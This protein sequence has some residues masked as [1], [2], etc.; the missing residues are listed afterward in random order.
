ML[1]LLSG[2]GPT[3]FGRTKLGADGPEF[4]P[5]PMAYFI[6]GLFQEKYDYSILENDT[7]QFRFI[8]EAELSEF[9]K[10]E[11]AKNQRHL[12]IPGLKNHQLKPHGFMAR[13]L[14]W[15]AAALK[16]TEGIDTVVPVFFR[17]TDSPEQE[18]FEEKLAS[19]DNGFAAAGFQNRGVAMLAKP[20]SEAWLLCLADDYQNGDKYEKGPGNDDSPNSLKARL[21]E[22][23]NP[24]SDYLTANDL[25]GF[26]KSLGHIEFERLSC[27]LVSFAEFMDRFN[28]ALDA[29]KD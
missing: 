7:G 23:I 28:R 29:T 15:K 18:D 13:A 12:I 21:R 25:V 20:K 26:I 4:I 5:G 14:G 17:D 11:K 1:F 10:A 19:I 3:D 6:D 9:A 8:S 2:E 22:K 24:E 27:E 16:K